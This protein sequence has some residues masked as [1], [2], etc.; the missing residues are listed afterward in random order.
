MNKAPCVISIAK[1]KKQNIQFQ[2]QDLPKHLKKKLLHKQI[3]SFI[4]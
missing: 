4:K 3:N 2:S 1:I